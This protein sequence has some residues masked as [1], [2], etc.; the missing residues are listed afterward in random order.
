[1]ATSRA[2]L[3]YN[4][5]A[6]YTHSIRFA[7]KNFI[8]YSHFHHFHQFQNVIVVKYI[9]GPTASVFFFFYLPSSF[10]FRRTKLRQLVSRIARRVRYAFQW[11]RV[12]R[13]Q[14]LY[15]TIYGLTWS[16]PGQVSADYHGGQHDSRQTKSSCNNHKLLVVR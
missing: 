16:D 6:S 13:F 9:I 1:M 4:I 7:S 8:F 10:F 11:A 3:P 15:Y 2:S 5:N 14:S 12:R